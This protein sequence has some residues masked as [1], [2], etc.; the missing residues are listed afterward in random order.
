MTE[1][2]LDCGVVD[3]LELACLHRYDLAVTMN[4]GEQFEG[5]ARN[6]TTNGERQECLILDTHGGERTIILADAKTAS[7]LTENDYFTELDLNKTEQS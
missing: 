1:S 3:N 5:K 2:T 7:A 4:N 6:L